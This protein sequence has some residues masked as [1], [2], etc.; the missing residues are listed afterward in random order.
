MLNELTI[1]IAGLKLFGQTYSGLE[2]DYRG[3][4]HVYEE[5]H[6]NDNYLKYCVILEEW[7]VLRSDEKSVSC[8]LRLLEKK[9][10]YITTFF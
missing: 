4:L 6:E 8:S 3:L 2:Y 9:M 1:Y 10:C 7:R 5:L